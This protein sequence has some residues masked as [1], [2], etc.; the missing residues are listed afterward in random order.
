MVAKS[1]TVRVAEDRVRRGT[2]RT[3]SCCL[4]QVKRLPAGTVELVLA[5]LPGLVQ[6]PTLQPSMPEEFSLPGFDAQPPALPTATAL[7]RS[8]TSMDR[9]DPRP[10]QRLFLGVLLQAHDA[11]L[12]AES[13]DVLRQHDCLAGKRLH[14]DCLHITLHSLGAAPMLHHLR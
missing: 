7:K 10:T 11:A 12:V 14:I 6:P 3:T 2:I 4:R 5:G 9:A 8:L 1:L 13:I